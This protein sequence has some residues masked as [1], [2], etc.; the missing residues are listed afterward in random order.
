[1]LLKSAASVLEEVD[2][3]EGAIVSEKTAIAGTAAERAREHCAG[4]RTAGS[5]R[6]LRA[7]RTKQALR[8]SDPEL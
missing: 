2:K 3:L 4:I 6:P 7:V 8:S 1:M 5:M